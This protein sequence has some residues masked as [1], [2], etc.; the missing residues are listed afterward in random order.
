M[1]DSLAD[2]DPIEVGGT[3]ERHSRTITAH[4]EIK[5]TVAYPVFEESRT[6][7]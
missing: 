5:K 7:Q 3:S 4:A 6:I 1:A 2:V